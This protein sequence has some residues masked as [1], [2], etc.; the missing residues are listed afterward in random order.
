MYMYV[1]V[2]FVPSMHHNRN[3]SSCCL[4]TF[5]HSYTIACKWMSKDSESRYSCIYTL[6]YVDKII[7][8][9]FTL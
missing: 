2:E 5:T 1:L 9:L 8:Y 3:W 4:T 6:M 7:E